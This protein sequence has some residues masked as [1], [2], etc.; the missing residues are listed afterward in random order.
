MDWPVV[1]PRFRDAL[2]PGGV[3]AIAG[4]REQRS[5][6]TDELLRIIQRYSTNRD[7][8]PYSLIDELTSRRLFNRLGSFATSPVI[9]TQPVADYIESWH[10]RNGLSRDRMGHAAA[11]AF[12]NEVRELLDS[13]GV[14]DAVTFQNV[15]TL[16]WGLPDG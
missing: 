15:G 9:H 10:S 5:A 11:E 4:R 12:D 6:W 14:R 2:L 1:M 13:H 3:L 16:T 8:H 7:F